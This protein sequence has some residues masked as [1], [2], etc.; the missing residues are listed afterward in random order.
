[1]TYKPILTN[2]WVLYQY[3]IW[4]IWYD[5]LVWRVYH[6]THTSNYHA[7]KRRIVFLAR[8]QILNR[9]FYNNLD[10]VYGDGSI[11]NFLNL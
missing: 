2:Q 11:N 1:M 3:Y 4:H 7:L 9:H 5:V 8:N 6:N 10:G